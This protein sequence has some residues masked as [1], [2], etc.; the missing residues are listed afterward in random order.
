LLQRREDVL[1]ERRV[2]FVAVPV[3]IELNERIRVDLDA[4]G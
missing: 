3:V 1:G 2:I 4:R